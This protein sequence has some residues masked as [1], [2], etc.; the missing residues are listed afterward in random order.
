MRWNTY[1]A[2][3]LVLKKTK[4][5]EKD[6]IVTLLLDDGSLVQAIARGARRPG[7]S[8]SGRME[9]CN[10]L[11]LLCARGRNLDIVQ[12]ASLINPAHCIY[13]LHQI[14]CALPLA[15]LTR[16]VLHTGLEQPRLYELVQATFALLSQCDAPRAYTISTAALWKIISQIGYCPNF[17]TCS[18]CGK[19]IQIDDPKIS[20][21]FSVKSGGLLCGSC[22]LKSS[23]N[24]SMNTIRWSRALIFS[25]YQDILSFDIDISILHDLNILF[26]KWIEYHLN[27][28]LRSFSYYLLQAEE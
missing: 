24:P 9:L 8:L 4:F 2:R 21:G 22:V 6:L 7:S 23:Q 12:D 5:S 26:L 14:N 20:F 27:I 18:E 11:K 15:E 3:G 28:T 17:D 19:T 10:N 1:H 13:E 25:T 16:K